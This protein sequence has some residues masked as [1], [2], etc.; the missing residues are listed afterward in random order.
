MFLIA[1]P[2]AFV[3]QW[4]AMPCHEIRIHPVLCFL[5]EKKNKFGIF[6]SNSKLRR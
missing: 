2:A 3:V 5:L 1:G 4:S 6:T